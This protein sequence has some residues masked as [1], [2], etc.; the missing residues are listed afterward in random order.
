MFDIGWSELFV[1][2]VA[3]LI[4]VGPKDLPVFLRTIGRYVGVL[5]RQAADFRAQF[6]D[7]IHETEMQQLKTDIQDIRRDVTGTLSATTQQITSELEDAQS[8]LDKADRDIRDETLGVTHP[9][10]LTGDSH[11][12][13]QEADDLMFEDDDI[14]AHNEKIMA[15]TRE[16]AVSDDAGAPNHKPE[17]KNK[18]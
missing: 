10:A 9:D 17:L 7:I 3:T 6:D 12:G 1:I 11:A 8:A 5:K 16:R 14:D 18:H 2:A 15:A 13:A 4:V